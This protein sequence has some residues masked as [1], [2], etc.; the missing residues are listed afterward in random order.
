M[1]A[2]WPL[3]DGTLLAPR[4][5]SHAADA[6]Y[7]G[8]AAIL[9]FLTVPPAEGVPIVTGGKTSFLVVLA[10]TVYFGV[11][12]LVAIALGARIARA[13]LRSHGHERCDHSSA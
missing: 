4:A 10:L 7:L 1:A 13:R 8:E 6:P 9:Y 12:L 3:P 2:S 5:V 11:T